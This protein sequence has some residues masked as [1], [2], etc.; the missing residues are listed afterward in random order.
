MRPDDAVRSLVSWQLS[1]GPRRRI[2]S[3]PP[4]VTALAD[5]HRVT[6]VVL[7][8]I[9][10]GA[11]V[12]ADPSVIAVLEE[13]HRH[14]LRQ[15]LAAEADVAL[16]ADRLA[17]AGIPMRVLKGCA[18]AHLDAADPGLR[19]TSDADVL[20]GRDALGDATRALG[21]LVD[22]DASVPDRRSEWTE[23]YGKDRTLRLTTGG[24]LDLHRAVAPGY[25]GLNDRY[26]WFAG[27]V[28]YRVAGRELTA[29][30]LEDRFVHALLH[31]GYADMIGL[32]SLRDVP[33][34][35]QELG[36]RWSD[37]LGPHDR[38]HPLIARGVQRTWAMLALGQHAIVDWAAGVRPDARQRFA[39]RCIGL[40][41][42]RQHWAGVAA[43]PPWRW[44]GLLVPIAVPSRTYLDH[45]GRSRLGHVRI[46][47]RRLIGDRTEGS[48]GR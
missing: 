11:V 33:V 26:D 32:H 18:T 17:D 41:G 43:L 31:A 44:P 36:D 24:W 34:L 38:L 4:G 14:L 47:G 27:G 30:A 2:D 22:V 45:L 48:G 28:S 46:T 37:A 16:V 15:S 39:L 42:S 23:R 35:L 3:L 5:F 40:P 29:L 9:R 10:D 13:R 6:G 21:R 12:D 20:V 7:D 1:I 8:A 25:F 19:L